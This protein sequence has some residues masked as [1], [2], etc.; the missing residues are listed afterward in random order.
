MSKHR[1]KRKTKQGLLGLAPHSHI[2]KLASTA[3]PDAPKAM[4]SMARQ[5]DCAR[6][7]LTTKS[8][9]DQGGAVE[10]ASASGRSKRPLHAIHDRRKRTK[11]TRGIPHVPQWPAMEPGA[12]SVKH[13]KLP[14]KGRHI[15]PATGKKLPAK[16]RHIDP[17]TGKKL[18]AKGRHIDPATGKKRGT[19]F[20]AAP[21]RAPPTAMPKVR[22]ASAAVTQAGKKSAAEAS[23]TDD[24]RGSSDNL[25]DATRKS[26]GNHQKLSSKKGKR[27][28]GVA[29]LTKSGDERRVEQGEARRVSRKRNGL[30]DAQV[31][32]NSH[33]DAGDGARRCHDG[34]DGPLLLL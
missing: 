11:Q 2:A 13:K 12:G 3:T 25:P 16:G 1:G 10:P 27:K 4:Q 24:L 6:H 34:E 9:G 32:L 33:N 22:D 23:T 5:Q 15:D 7:S 28:T 19:L 31:C 14:A 26:G 20:S 21:S 29:L 18:P 30:V 17:A 8:C